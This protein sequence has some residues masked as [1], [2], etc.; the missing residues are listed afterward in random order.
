MSKNYGKVIWE[1]F[2][3]VTGMNFLL[4]HIQSECSNQNLDI[5]TVICFLKK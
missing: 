2:G 1:N 5:I 3:F 4:E